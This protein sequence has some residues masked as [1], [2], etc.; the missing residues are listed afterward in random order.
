MDTSEYA[1]VI[2]TI[3][4]YVDKCLFKPSPTWPEHEFRRR[5]YE[6]WAVDELAERMLD[7][8]DLLPFHISGREH[9]DPIEVIREFVDEMDGYCDMSDDRKSWSI[10][11][12][13]RDVGEEI[14]DLFDDRKN[15]IFSKGECK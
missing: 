1:N 9:K 6:R 3:Q 14:L 7:E 12:I 4:D 11:S 5:C 8:A 10:F 13:A 15:L 2:R